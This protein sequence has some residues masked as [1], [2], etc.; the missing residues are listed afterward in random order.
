MYVYIDNKKK[1]LKKMYRKIRTDV[2]GNP[3]DKL[4]MS[5]FHDVSNEVTNST[6]THNLDTIESIVKKYNHHH[7]HHTT[8]SSEEILLTA[9]KLYAELFVA[10][11][12]GKVA[13]SVVSSVL[14]DV[15]TESIDFQFVSSKE[16]IVDNTIHMYLIERN[17]Y[18]RY[19]PVFCVVS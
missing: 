13:Q 3:F 12:N 15:L 14:K 10:T 1:S 2:V 4:T 11:M 19:G 16:I 8:P 7:H 17:D 6:W 18:F 9:T 5:L